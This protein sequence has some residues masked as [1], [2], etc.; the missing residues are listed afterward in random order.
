LL[1]DFIT[2]SCAVAIANLPWKAVFH[3]S[4]AKG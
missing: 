1:L 3:L 4:N 2:V